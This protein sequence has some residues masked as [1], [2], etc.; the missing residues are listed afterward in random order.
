[1]ADLWSTMEQGKLLFSSNV[2]QLLLVIPIYCRSF[3]L[4][5]YF[6]LSLLLLV[7]LVLV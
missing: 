1:M 7:V 3:Y 6:N 2:F 4:F 5:I